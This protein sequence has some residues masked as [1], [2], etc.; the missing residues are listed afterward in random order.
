MRNPQG[1]EAS[2]NSPSDHRTL[3]TGRDVYPL[4]QTRKEVPLQKEL[5]EETRKPRQESLDLET[6]SPEEEREVVAIRKDEITKEVEKEISGNRDEDSELSLT[7]GTR[8]VSYQL[9]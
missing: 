4:T 1:E 7:A 3:G 6:H 8:K 5:E 2:L 9:S